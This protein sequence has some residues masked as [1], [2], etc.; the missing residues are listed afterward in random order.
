MVD[1][2]MGVQSDQ[3]GHKD[4]DSYHEKAYVYQAMDMHIGFRGNW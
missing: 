1:H 2:I 3:G 4:T